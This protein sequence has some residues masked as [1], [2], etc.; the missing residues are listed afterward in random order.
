[1]SNIRLPSPESLTLTLTLILIETIRRDYYETSYEA[2]EKAQT[3][4]GP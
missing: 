2:G 3:R 4:H 1:M